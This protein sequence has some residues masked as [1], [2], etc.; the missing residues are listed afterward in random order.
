MKPDRR[1]RKGPRSA[2][3]IP[4]DNTQVVAT[5]TTNASGYVNFSNVPA[6]TYDLQVTD[7]GHS[8]YDS[9]FTVV[10]GITNNDEVFI[11]AP[12]RELHME[13]GADHDPGHL[14][15]PAPDRVPDR[16]AGPRGHDHG[17]VLHSDTRC[18]VNR[19]ASTSR[20]PTTA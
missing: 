15:D 13:R 9:S 3:S 16:R 12:V 2:C 20:S 4:Y 10:P 19:R 18:R 1:T 14:P 6:G 7:T 11:A 17:A 5:G 8:N